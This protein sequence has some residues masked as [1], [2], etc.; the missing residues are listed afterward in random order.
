V[1][2]EWQ[3]LWIYWHFTNYFTDSCEAALHLNP[4]FYDILGAKPDI[5][6]FPEG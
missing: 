4:C 6:G 3:F 5:K 1:F 2:A